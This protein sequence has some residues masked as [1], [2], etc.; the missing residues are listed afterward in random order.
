M[1]KTILFDLDGTLTDPAEGITHSVMYALRKW[2]I[3]VEDRRE[4]FRF[5]GPPLKDS[6]MTYYGFSEADAERAVE[7]YRVYFRDKG[8]FENTVYPGI[9]DMLRT[10]KEAGRTLAIAT[11]KP[12]VFAREILAHFGLADYFTVI[13]GAT[14]DGTRSGKADVVAYALERLGYPGRATTVMVGDRHHDIEGANAH[15]LDSIAVLWGYGDEA[16]HKAAGATHIVKT[17][18]TLED[19]LLS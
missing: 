4:L 15:L 7:E 10:L 17:I 14:M 12:E 3:A 18:S 11:S 1:Y 16:E 13:A 5:I 8:K 6:F 19:L 2:G 9:P